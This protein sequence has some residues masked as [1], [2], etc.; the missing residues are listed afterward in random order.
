MSDKE[1]KIQGYTK[2]KL[3]ELLPAVY[4]QR[5]I[6][7]G[8]PLEG[9]V[10]IIASQV[11]LMEEDIGGLYDNWFVETCDEW[12]TAYIADLVGARSL[13]ASKAS[14]KSSNPVSQRAYVANTIGYRRRKGTLAMLEQLAHDVTQWGAHAVEFFQL[15]SSTQHLNHLRLQ[16]HRTPD[17]RHTAA[18]DLLNTPFDTIAHTVEARRI[19]S[20]R[21]YYNI[22]NTGL[23]LWRL[24]ALPSNAAPAFRM[25]GRKFTFSP[26]G[27]EVP[28]FNT[29]MTETS[30]TQ[31]SGELNVPAPIRIRALYD[32]LGSYY[33]RS[34][35]LSIKY[36]GEAKRTE[37]SARNIKVCTLADWREP[38]AGK[39]AIDPVLGRISLSK[40]ATEIRAI[41]YYG[42]SRKMGGGFYRRTEHDDDFD[43]EP[44]VYKISR[45]RAFVWNKVPSDPKESSHLRDIL[46][47][48]SDLAVVW[49][50]EG[51][52]FTKESG[53]RRISMTDGTHSLSI[54]LGTGDETAVLEVDGD[55]IHTFDAR[56]ADDGT[57]Y[58]SKANKAREQIY[59]SINE[60]L[61]WWEKDRS[62]EAAFEILDS[63]VY[64][65][66]V[67]VSLP[68]GFALRMAAAQEQ[69]PILRSLRVQGETGS[70]L[71]LD[72]LWIN[73]PT[74]AP[75]VKVMPGDMESITFRHCTLVPGQNTAERKVAIGVKSYIRRRLCSWAKVVSVKSH[76]AD[77]AMFLNQKVGL[78]WIDISFIEDKKKKSIFTMDAGGKLIT[79][80]AGHD[81]LQI[82]LE[83]PD[84]PGDKET[85]AVLS[86]KNNGGDWKKVYE[87]T[88][89]T[90]NGK[91]MYLEGANDNLKVSLDNSISGR[92]N[93]LDS[94]VLTWSRILS[95]TQE[96]DR[97]YLRKFLRSNFD[98][99]W[100]E[101]DTAFKADGANKIT[102][103]GDGHSLA[104]ERAGN[105]TLT[106][107]LFID[108][109]RMH[110]FAYRDGRVYTQSDA[111][112][113]ANDS[114]I[115]GKGN[116]EAV[117]ADSALIENSTVFGKTRVD[118][119]DLASNSIFTDLV[120]V[121]VRQQG[122]V[123][124]SYIPRGSKTPQKY[125]C[126]PEE[127]KQNVRPSFT[128]TKYG[129][130][131]Y[132]QLHRH[133]DMEVLEGA[134]NGA[135][136]GAFHSIYQPQRISDLKAALDEYLRF[137]LEAGVFLVT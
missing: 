26:L 57:I 5:D 55:D 67:R 12:V 39:V 104:I 96:D 76:A 23:F 72:G 102:A 125:K 53:D 50:E 64:D 33:G 25:A 60:A 83:E 2:D 17:L 65:R 134:D 37:I 81:S 108:G 36:A 110:E 59:E 91:N 120:N 101:N 95:P 27:Y 40:D 74:T 28:I 31:I 20:G 118:T 10:D 87:F 105:E 63:E 22:P 89:L 9:L 66:N 1:P 24:A 70:K 121:K 6:K 46:H 13:S 131:G 38:E 4:R 136:M 107:V 21:G 80:S 84:K 77:L 16:N 68:V 14:A 119:M 92:V 86:K 133:V 93:V 3:Y 103:E 18:L 100:M 116:T 123:R 61:I 130:P 78:E 124:F 73:N 132:A 82:E 71:I 41:H 34:V 117:E 137:G 54:S 8:K 85:R 69:R 47:N 126:Q 52:T 29:P 88:V 113:I 109:I 97:R 99:S 94:L 62:S 128:S 56:K 112:F 35:S 11:H 42:F 90:E 114:I 115:D 30:A 45:Q 58:V 48:D 106:A 79:Y 49:V 7:L 51:L 111:R 43:G 44:V 75:H 127:L 32:D 129:D 19:T 122:C 98:L 135:E 15:L